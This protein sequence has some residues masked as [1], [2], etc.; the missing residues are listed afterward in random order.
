MATE[1]ILPEL[2][3]TIKEGGVLEVRVKP[4]DTLAAGDIVVVIEAEKSTVEVPTEVAGKVSEVLVK[5]GQ[6]IK[7]GTVLVRMDGVTASAP[8]EAKPAV[9]AAA[10]AA[11]APAPAPTVAAAP[12]ARNG[13]AAPAT[14][15]RFQADQLVPAGPATR[16]LA[17]KLGVDLTSVAGTGPRGRVTQDDVI[18]AAGR[19]MGGGAGVPV[20]PLPDFSKWGPIEA[21]PLDFVRKKTAEQMALSWS[22]IPHVTHNDL[23][24]TTDLEAF[25]RNHDAKG[26]KLTVTAFALKACAVALREFPHFNASLDLAGGQLIR[27]NYIH[28]G[29]AV[30]TDRGL[31]VPVLRDV[32]KKSIRE[33]AGELT[34]IAE[35]ARNRKLG[36]DDMKGGTFTISNLGGIGGTGFTPIVNWPEVAILGMSRSRYEP[37]WKDGAFV[38]RLMLPLSLSYDHRVI[39]GADGA[40]FTRRVASLL[41]NPM[42]LL[43][44]A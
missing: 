5:P 25:R 36:P 6:T 10:A 19:S 33:L 14:Q 13:D 27:K 31:L 39:D 1:I 44:E 28:I 20:P 4:G 43:V 29:V 7:P 38:P 37:V 21:K 17:R 3:E 9:A 22:Q 11:P 18:A 42:L 40:R 12:P 26:P 32:D 16:R 30:D 24:D 41:E 34:E 23:A 15:P 35:K 8:A 2:G